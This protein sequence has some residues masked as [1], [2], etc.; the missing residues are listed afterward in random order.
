MKEEEVQQE[1]ERQQKF[2]LEMKRIHRDNFEYWLRKQVK[3]A[4]S[5]IPILGGKLYYYKGI[6][7]DIP[8]WRR[9]YIKIKEEI[10]KGFHKKG[11]R[12][13]K[14]ILSKLFGQY[15]KIFL[16]ALLLHP[17]EEIRK[18][19][20]KLFLEFKEKKENLAKAIL[21]WTLSF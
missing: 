1:I 4:V 2:L 12:D 15:S 8:E 11:S 19:G 16:D 5:I 7:K 10:E 18:M 9:E 17:D 3:R 6:S 21:E 20:E 13:E 14:L